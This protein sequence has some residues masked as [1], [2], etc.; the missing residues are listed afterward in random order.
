MIN[1]CNGLLHQNVSRNRTNSNK[2]ILLER[3][4]GG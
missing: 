4:E 2:H 3:T 1:N